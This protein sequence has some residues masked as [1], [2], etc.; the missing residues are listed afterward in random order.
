MRRSAKNRESFLKLG[1]QQDVVFLTLI[2]GET[3]DLNVG[4]KA[5]EGDHLVVMV[6]LPALRASFCYW[7]AG[8]PL[9]HSV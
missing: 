4:V 8:I 1:T 5:N 6:I 7:K 2:A 9:Y 3:V